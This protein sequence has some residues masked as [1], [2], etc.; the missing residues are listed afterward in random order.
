MNQENVSIDLQE[1]EI[2]LANRQF[3][4]A[5]VI[6]KNFESKASGNVYLAVGGGCLCGPAGWIIWRGRWH[7]SGAGVFLQFHRPWLCGR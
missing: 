3:A 4:N 6:L 2:N 1:F 7:G 5:N